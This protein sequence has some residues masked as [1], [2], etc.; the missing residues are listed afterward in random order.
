M[1]SSTR[2]SERQLLQEAL[3]AHSSK[4][5]PLAEVL[6]REL[7]KKVPQSFEA[8]RGLGILNIETS[9]FA[10][11][12][13][14]LTQALALR[15]FDV[16]L[17]NNVGMCLLLTGKAGEALGYFDHALTIK[18]F[19]TDLL[20]NR[21]N[22]HADL[23]DYHAA[24]ADYLSVLDQTTDNGTV[25]YN[26]GRI[27]FLQ[28]Q[29]EDALKNFEK[30]RS[31]LP[32][33]LSVVQ[34]LAA[35]LIKLGKY[36]EA[37]S[38]YE[39]LIKLHPNLPELWS[40]QSAAL[41]QLG[42]FQA[43]RLSAEQAI[44]IDKNYPEAWV[45]F[46]NALRGLKKLDD[47]LCAFERAIALRRNQYPQAWLFRGDVLALLGK[48]DEALSSYDTALSLDKTFPEFWGGR[49]N[50]LKVLR[51]YKEA[52]D[53]FDKAIELNPSY[54]EAISNRGDMYATMGKN[55]EALRD[56]AYA[57]ELKGS[58]AEL[59]SNFGNVQADL[60]LLDQ[61]LHSYDEALN[62]DPDHARAHLN[63]GICLFRLDRFD[64][65]WMEYEWRWPAAG[66][67]EAESYKR[68]GQLWSGQPARQLVIWGEQGIGDQILYLSRLK[69]MTNFVD[70][71]ILEID[72]RLH[73][74]VERSFTLESISINP[75][76][77]TAGVSDFHLP[78]AEI[79]RHAPEKHHPIGGYLKPDFD[80]VDRLKREMKSEG[81]KIIGLN[82][83]SDSRLSASKSLSLAD[84]A[85]A[86]ARNNFYYV[87]LQGDGPTKSAHEI[88]ESCGVKI[89]DLP[90]VDKFN[91]I[92]TLAALISACDLVISCSNSTAH[93]SGALGQKTLLLLPFG[94]GKLW[95][96][97]QQRDTFSRW[98]PS[99]EIIQR[100]CSDPDWQACVERLSEK[101]SGLN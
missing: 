72:P 40:N 86:L 98:Y 16:D 1:S 33:Q 63:R 87:S 76:S 88:F 65:G 61:A 42:N 9:N 69:T 54:A 2:S 80:K 13:E 62:L 90:N 85:P 45:S 12:L 22:A 3:K 21:A 10:G 50:A 81:R 18:P 74:L 46:G 14:F 75:G 99:I 57:I 100:Q 34:N 51:R 36:E 19:D 94:R 79:W 39:P 26:L 8:T 73:N 35:T 47:A 93:L 95:Y 53:A 7:L 17:M 25:F 29:F 67:A 28:S 56:C 89:N 4:N 37:L 20:L 96:W 68:R 84:L 24:E 6:Y 64:L 91:D 97:S 78:I 15:P 41:E 59:W 11:A 52:L 23:R 44:L 60:G 70:Q 31:Y 92:D 30:A 55:Q 77:G 66:I 49:A 58:S 101:L 32:N 38:E 5:L 27:Q 83:S 82:W 43:A 71:I 48:F